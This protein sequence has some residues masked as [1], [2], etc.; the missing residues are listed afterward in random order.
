MSIHLISLLVLAAVFLCA[1]V[2]PVNMGLLGFAAAFGVGVFAAG[3][4]AKD[5]FAGFPA[6][7]FLTL[8]GV[9]YLFAFASANG[10]I[11]RHVDAAARSADARAAVMTRL[12]YALAGLITAVGAPGPG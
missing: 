2:L 10:A 6:D 12:E 5:V 11:D 3:M 7:L 8:V 4:A 1:A 9:T